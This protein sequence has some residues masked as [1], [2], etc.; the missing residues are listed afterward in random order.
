[1]KKFNPRKPIKQ[2]WSEI[3]AQEQRLKEETKDPQAGFEKVLIY[4]TGGKQGV[5]IPMVYRKK[6]NNGDFYQVSEKIYAT[7]LYCPFTGRQLY[8]ELYQEK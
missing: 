6:F 8:E 1:M 4:G 7:I 2:N 5:G 3:F